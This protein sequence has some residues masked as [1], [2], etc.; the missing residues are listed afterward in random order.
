M[1]EMFLGCEALSSLTLGKATTLLAGTGL[2]GLSGTEDAFW[3]L[4][5]QNALNYN[6]QDENASLEA[7]KAVLQNLPEGE[8]QTFTYAT[9][10]LT[11]NA[12]GGHFGDDEAATEAFL[13]GNP[14]EAIS[15]DQGEGFN[16]TPIPSRADYD[17]VGYA[18][19]EGTS[20]VA[21]PSVFPAAGENT[22][23]YAVWQKHP[24]VVKS[25][26]DDGVALTFRYGG[27]PEG[28]EKSDW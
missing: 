13:Y 12:Q 10:R 9:M 3:R 22:V 18:A 15:S 8:T 6:V 1:N 7:I 23:F 19:T 17:Y 28:S 20:D 4:S 21:T 14:G 2:R 25:E 16:Y 24:Y 11:Y 26:G 27:Q 5:M